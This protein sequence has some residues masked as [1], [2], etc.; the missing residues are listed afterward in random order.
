MLDALTLSQLNDRLAS[1]VQNHRSMIKHSL[2]TSVNIK[3]VL[4]S[5]KSDTAIASHIEKVRTDYNANTS[6]AEHA[7][8]TYSNYGA[9]FL[10]S[11]KC[12]PKSVFQMV[13]QLAALALFGYT[14]ACWETVSVA[15]FHMGR[16]E[17]IQVILPAVAAF[18]AVANDTTVPLIERRQLLLGAM[19]AHAGAVSKASRGQSAERNLS[20]LRVLLR[21]GEE[22]PTLYH[23]PVYKR[24]RP[25][26]IMSHCFE[27]GMLE[28]GFLFRDPEAVWVHYE[29]YDER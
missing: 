29:V 22:T 4:L 10:R 18:L 23:D 7:F 25:R 26:K 15:Q 8:L 3:P 28:K 21:E 9:T 2:S 24:A 5:L 14:P 13:V 19:R 27:T 20:A 11:Q 1:A 6:S 17:I 16:V 12:S